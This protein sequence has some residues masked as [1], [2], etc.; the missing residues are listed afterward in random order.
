MPQ[1]FDWLGKQPERQSP[2]S[3]HIA[4]FWTMRGASNHVLTCA[5]YQTDTGIELRTSY[6]AD[7]IVATPLFR[8]PNADE[9]VAEHAD[10]WR[11]NLMLKGFIE[12][13]EQGNDIADDI[14]DR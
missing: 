9:L 1:D 3:E 7:N 8:G 2:R 11:L 14:E 6:G 5:A 10:S 4:T 12:V 13:D